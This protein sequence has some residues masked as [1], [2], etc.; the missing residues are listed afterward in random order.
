VALDQFKKGITPRT[1]SIN[2]GLQYPLINNLYY[3]YRHT[4]NP[5]RVLLGSGRPRKVS[6]SIVNEIKSFINKDENRFLSMAKFKSEFESYMMNQKHQN[7]DLSVRTYSNYIMSRKE[8]NYSYKRVNTRTY[9]GRPDDIELILS[10]KDFSKR[11][12]YLTSLGLTPIWIDECGFNPIER[13]PL[14]GYAA[15]GKKL[16]GVVP[17][18]ANIHYTLVAAITADK[19]LGFMVFA[20]TMKGNDF[21]YFIVKLAMAYST[22]MKNCFIVM[23][24]LR[25][26]Y[27]S[28]YYK[29][30]RRDL[31][32]LFLPSRSP[33]LNGIETVFSILKGMMR[34]KKVNS[35]FELLREVNSCI[36]T[37]SSEIYQNI[38]AEVN[39]KIYLALN[40]KDLIL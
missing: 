21:Y 8:I 7:V 20:R 18:K 37:Q 16:K 36:N 38:A 10:R 17:S 35:W 12:L 34:K 31:A 15:R 13:F 28:R 32:F 27:T 1:I 25:Q 23:D 19:M 26:H 5:G 9:F 3:R 4:S 2:L 14:Y 11:F 33:Q 30:V 24:N 29:V 22:L 6:H 39:R 40:C